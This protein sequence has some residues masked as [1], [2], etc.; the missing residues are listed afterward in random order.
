[1][2]TRVTVMPRR[3]SSR[4]L[5]MRR[6]AGCGRVRGRGRVRH[7]AMQARFLCRHVDSLPV[8]RMEGANARNVPTGGVLPTQTIDRNWMT[9]LAVRELEDRAEA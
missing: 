1:V 9:V 3:S 8:H 4:R 6:K 5:A 7:A 2:D